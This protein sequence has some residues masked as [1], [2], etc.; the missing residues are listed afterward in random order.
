MDKKILS[1][2]VNSGIGRK[3]LVAKYN[4]T[5]NE[6]RSYKSIAN[7]IDVIKDLFE[8]DED[9]IVNSIKLKKSKQRL[10]DLNRINNK[11]HREEYRVENAVLEY[12]KELVEVFRDNPYKPNTKVFKT[13]E[14]S[15]V[16]IVQISD[17][18]FN[19]LINLDTNKYDFRIASK[20]L[21]K[22]AIDAT[23]YLKANDCT[24]VFIMLT[25]DLVNSDRRLD[26]LVSMA[27]N[28]AKATF[29]SVQLLQYFI[30]HLNRKFN[31]HVAGICGNES[32]VGKDFSFSNELVSDNYDFTIFNM[33][34]ELFKGCKG[35]T[36]LGLNDDSEEVVSVNGKNILIVHG[37]QFGKDLTK[38]ISKMVRKY[39][40]QN[41]IIHY[42][43]FG[44]IHEAYISDCFSRSASLCGSNAYS[45]GNLIL[46]SRASQNVF[47]V[48]KESIDGIKIDLQN[49]DQ[50]E[51]YDIT[52][53]ENAYNP[54]SVDKAKKKT[55]ILSITI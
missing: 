21:Q 8:T 43:L 17:A 10:Q 52:E 32:R 37:N 24:D 29:I 7:N 39:A 45:E 6:A 54:K 26:E 13:K 40:D 2:A 48:G 19:E 34:R 31:I 27:T 46:V 4:I 22:Y 42:T 53:L 33:L 38:E 3:A 28:R 18:H 50:Y 51:G 11:L 30:E 9:L 55:T 25:G 23:K 36:F 41:I 20:R 12:V 5:E 14:G 16:G 15:K 49:V 1:D 47:I 44:H 35:V